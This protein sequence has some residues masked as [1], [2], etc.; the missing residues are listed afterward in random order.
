MVHS[1]EEKV[2]TQ[3][4]RCYKEAVVCTFANPGFEEELRCAVPS[5]GPQPDMREVGGS[6]E[7]QYRGTGE[8]G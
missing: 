3:T 1:F 6:K 4:C 5:E 2:K 8:V 7:R